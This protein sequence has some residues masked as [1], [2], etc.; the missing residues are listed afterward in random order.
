MAKIKYQKKELYF[1]IDTLNL[2]DLI[3]KKIAIPKRKAV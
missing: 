2:D 1:A 3:T